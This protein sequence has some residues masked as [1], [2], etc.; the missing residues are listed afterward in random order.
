MVGTMKGVIIRGLVRRRPLLAIQRGW[1]VIGTARPFPAQ[2]FPFCRSRRI[3][4]RQPAC[5]HRARARCTRSTSILH[6]QSSILVNPLDKQYPTLVP[7]RP[8]FSFLSITTPPTVPL[9]P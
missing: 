6:P 3:L 9:P 4:E 2:S 7:P 1:T 5:Q 8:F